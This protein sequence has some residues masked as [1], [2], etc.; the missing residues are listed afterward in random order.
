MG[1]VDALIRKLKSNQMILLWT[2][3]VMALVGLFLVWEKDALTCDFERKIYD[4]AASG[5][6]QVA[7]AL[8]QAKREHKRVLLQFGANWC[9]WCHRLHCLMESDAGVRDE[10]KADYV[11]VLIDV[12]NGHNTDVDAQYGD[13]VQNGLPVIVLLDAEGKLLTTKS[14]GD[15]ASGP[16]HDPGKVLAF[17]TEWKAR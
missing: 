5:T 14:S 2:L 7:E 13:P 10:L 17:L 3:W 1:G 11:T 12:D 9:G 6:K 16:Q 4:P 15:L 8:A